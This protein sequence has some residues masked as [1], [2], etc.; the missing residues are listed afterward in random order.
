MLGCFSLVA[1]ARAHSPAVVHGKDGITLPPPPAVQTQ[2]VVDTYGSPDA[3]IKVTDNYRY[4]ED[5][6]SPATRAYITAENTYTQKYFDQVK[7]LPETRTQMAALLKVDF[8][9]TP[10]KRGET[11]FFTR[12]LAGENQG[13]IYM[14]LG[15]HGE[16]I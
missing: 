2:P 14:R 8:M 4:L 5:A 3:P 15:L 10:E 12:R 6:K 11:Y 1:A 7:T 13:S 9:S 16:D